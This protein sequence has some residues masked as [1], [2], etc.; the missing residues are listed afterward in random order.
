[1][2]MLGW[3]F[4]V[5]NQIVYDRAANFVDEVRYTS[6]S[7]FVDP[8]PF[9]AQYLMFT[10]ELF[11]VNQAWQ[12]V[13]HIGV[14]FFLMVYTF[15]FA[16]LFTSLSE[17]EQK[18]IDP[19]NLHHIFSII[20]FMSGAAF[21][22]LIILRR[23][24]VFCPEIRRAL[25]T[26]FR[27]VYPMPG[28]TPENL[29]LLLSTVE[30]E[31]VVWA[32]PSFTAKTT[33]NTWL[34]ALMLV[35]TH[36]HLFLAIFLSTTPEFCTIQLATSNKVVNVF[37]MGSPQYGDPPR[38]IPAMEDMGKHH[39]LTVGRYRVFPGND[40]YMDRFGIRSCKIVGCETGLTVGNPRK[41]DPFAD[42]SICL[43]MFSLETASTNDTRLSAP[44]V[45]YRL[46]VSTENEVWKVATDFTSSNQGM[47]V[48]MQCVSE[49]GVYVER[50]CLRT[51]TRYKG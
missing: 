18:H 2:M 5:T 22:L 11:K 8:K 42:L 3:V 51:K 10:S 27:E 32:V 26:R 9:I 33:I 37:S 48:L 17:G 34:C 7:T 13:M 23:W 45:S 16:C 1:L 14:S 6:A 44:F 28:T 19:A 4:I 21:F 35:S 30:Q 20:T 38:L 49:V 46:R 31:P 25:T 39:F 40:Y 29:S 24:E 50:M 15:S 36:T 12:S 43:Q 41:I 47:F